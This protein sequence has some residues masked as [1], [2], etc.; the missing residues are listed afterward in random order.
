LLLSLFYLRIP[1]GLYHARAGGFC[2]QKGA[3]DPVG[4]FSV[5]K[6]N[7]Y[8]SGRGAIIIPRLRDGR[9]G[10]DRAAGDSGQKVAVAFPYTVSIA[11]VAESVRKGESIC[12]RK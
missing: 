6:E 11:M 1:R 9:L 2:K 4:P 8:I 3:G 12:G 5:M 10:R 7:E